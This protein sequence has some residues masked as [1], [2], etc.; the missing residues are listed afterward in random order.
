MTTLTPAED[1]QT[2]MALRAEIDSLDRQ[3][4]AMLAKRATYIDRA[5]ELKRSDGLP[6][7]I[8]VR[9]EAVVNNARGAAVA[10]GLDPDLVEHLWR[11]LID[12]SIAREAR[13]IDLG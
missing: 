1:C 4:V 3:L 12:W 2:M 11:E 9:V 10:A 5:I 13:E 8:P 6:A 7:R